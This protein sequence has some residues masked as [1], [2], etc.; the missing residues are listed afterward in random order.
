MERKWSVSY[1]ELTW[2]QLSPAEAALLTAA[3]AAAEKAYAP[4]SGFP[5][6]AAA[7]L[8]TG[9]TYTANNQ[10]NLAYPS[11]LC[12]ERVLVFY[13]GAQGLIP[14]VEALAV[15][16]PKLPHPVMPC[17]ACRQVL[18]EYQQMSLRPWTLIF[19]GRSPIVYRFE[20]VE[21]LLPFAFVWR[22]A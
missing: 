12:A 8:L 3:Q 13:L 4:Y 11:G 22:P 14:Q 1:E 5:V 9:E 21:S 7:R 19:A 20:G 18:H 16:A 2:A 6:G 15:Y 17:G 10:E